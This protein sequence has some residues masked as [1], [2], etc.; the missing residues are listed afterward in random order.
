MKKI[1][2][3]LALI[4]TLAISGCVTG[5]KTVKPSSSETGNPAPITIEEKGV[6]GTP[7]VVSN[8]PIKLV[9]TAVSEDIKPYPISEPA[10]EPVKIQYSQIADR[11]SEFIDM[12]ENSIVSGENIYSGVS[13]NKLTTLEIK[14]DRND[15][16]EASMKLIYP[17]GI[18]KVSAELNNAMMSRF[19]KN[20][21][22]EFPDWD[23]RIKEIL[24]K[25]YSMK[26]SVQGVAREDIEISNKNIQILYDKNADYIVVTLKHQL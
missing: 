16:K 3:S 9:M 1:N 12:E 2:L 4:V 24:D 21:A 7:I 22:P 19:L 23:N 13:E 15:V 26:T 10:Q 18:D 6:S 14:G 25:F 5:A 8:N 17:Q 20:A 11:I